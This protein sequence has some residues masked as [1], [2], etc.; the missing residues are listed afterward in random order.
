MFKGTIEGTTIYTDEWMSDGHYTNYYLSK[1]SQG[2]GFYKVTNPNGQNISANRCYLPIP[3]IWDDGYVGGS[4]TIT[5][6]S[7][8]QLPYFTGQSI[9]FTNVPGLKAYTA[10]GYNYTTGVI[11]LTRVMKVPSQ[12]GI[13]I[14]ADEAGEYSIPTDQI[15]SVYKNMFTGS[16]YE[17]TIYTTE[18]KDGIEYIN[19]YLSNG[20]SGLGYYK[21]TNANGVNMKANRSYLQIPNRDTAAGARSMNGNASFSKMVISDNDD[22]VIAI[23]LL[24]G[25]IGDDE[26]TTGIR[27]AQFEEAEPDAYYTLQG[28]RVENPRK[29]I[30][31]KN[32]KKV[33]VK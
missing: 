29:G 11:W 21:V 31:I 5:V 25:M 10:T 13:L 8:K 33:V 16:L 7:A 20:A 28:Q 32:G 6:S 9:D 27:N 19:Y 12:T 22:D 18:E 30:Y 23:P 17:Q 2:V 3:D 26:E 1:G 14:I 4:E 24:G 15:A